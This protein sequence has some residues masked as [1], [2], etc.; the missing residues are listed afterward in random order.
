MRNFLH[1]FF[2]IS[3][4]FYKANAVIPWQDFA[5]THNT[6]KKQYQK[7]SPMVAKASEKVLANI[8]FNG[9]DYDK[10][11]K[12]PDIKPED[13]KI[14][15][16]LGELFPSPDGFNFVA[17]QRAFDPFGN[18]QHK[19]EI[20][21]DIIQILHDEK[22]SD[23]TNLI[24]EKLQLSNLGNKTNKS[25]IQKAAQLIIEAHRQQKEWEEASKNI[26]PENILE[27]MLLTY[28]NKISN[29]RDDL[30]KLTFFWDNE[31]LP[32]YSAFDFEA[33]EKKH[34][35]NNLKNYEDAFLLSNGYETYG[36]PVAQPVTYKTTNVTIDKKIYSF[37]DCGET[38]IRNILSLL[39]AGSGGFVNQEN[40]KELEN[41]IE[42]I[43]GGKQSNIWQGVLEYFKNNPQISGTD[44]SHSDWANL[45]ANLNHK[46]T[47]KL[48]YNKVIYKQKSS[49]QKPEN[50]YEI[51][52]QAN[53]AKGIINALNVIGHLIPDQKLNAKWL[54]KNKEEIEQGKIA[55]T[56]EDFV[57]YATQIKEKLKRLCELLSRDNFTV[58]WQGNIESPW[59]EITFKVNGN[60]VF[61]WEITTGHFQVDLKLKNVNDVRE[62]FKNID[63]GNF[64]LNSLFPQDLSDKKKPYYV[65]KQNLRDPD[66]VIASCEF[67]ISLNNSLE[68]WL[69]IMAKWISK[70]PDDEYADKIVA[71][72]LFLSKQEDIIKQNIN[73]N[74]KQRLEIIQSH[75]IR[76]EENNTLKIKL[77]KDFED[78]DLKKVVEKYPD[79]NVLDL[80]SC[81]KITDAGLEHLSKLDNLTSLD[82]ANCPYITN[83]GLAHLS[84]FTNLTS[85]SLKSCNKITDKGLEHL[86]NL[87]NLTSLNLNSCWKITDKGL[88]HLS[89]LTNLTSLN[90]GSC[91][92]ITFYSTKY[93]RNINKNLEII[94]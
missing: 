42:W 37:P 66:Y 10:K 45:V 59:T 74:K 41:N 79:L 28:F 31:G 36:R 38:S 88:E 49:E 92:K 67:L 89:K 68:N 46:N 53:G 61:D 13:D 29:S 83:D 64:W 9:P 87:T 54:D 75:H 27:I 60:Q 35:L 23:K 34:N 44:K 6:T 52:S 84:N 18:I 16:L 80:E 76:E 20:I 40:L 81:N 26:Y 5:G 93:L 43:E 19:T 63:F 50:D 51:T 21:N 56:K 3:I 8:R 94:R 7:F 25:K 22:I 91:W 30:K 69:P 73:N 86:G 1:L 77:K 65:Y 15:I 12:I 2:A 58:E 11:N 33:Y 4:L 78:D 24:L 82:L 14:A 72:W 47:D 48:N 85:L 71:K 90:L 39:L 62:N 32:D 55:T 57:H 70:L 17:N